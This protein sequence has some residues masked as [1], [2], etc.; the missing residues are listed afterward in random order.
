M[1]YVR[2]VIEENYRFE[3]I[4]CSRC[5]FRAHSRGN[6]LEAQEF[7]AV[8]HIGGFASVFGDGTRVTC[9]LCQYCIQELVGPYCHVSEENDAWNGTR[10]TTS[11]D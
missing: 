1:L 6:D 4:E 10:E 7:Q 9:H 3:E 8:D 2:Q 11:E 5:G